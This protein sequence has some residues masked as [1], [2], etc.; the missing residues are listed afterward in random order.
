MSAWRKLILLGIVFSVAWGCGSTKGDADMEAE[1]LASTAKGS[2]VSD[3]NLRAQSLLANMSLEQK[4][5]QMIQGE[6]KHVTPDDVRRYGLG[7]VLNG[8]G[9]FPANNK[10]SSIGDW[11]DL[12]DAYRQ[13]SLDTSQGGAGIPILWGTDA[14]HGH[15]NVIG[16]TLFPHN[17]G[18]GAVNDPE[19]I[20]RIGRATAK[21]VAA[22]GID[23]IFAPTV[24]V[25]LDDRWGR[26]YE[27]Y[28]DRPEIVK[29]YSGVIVEALQEQGLLATAKHFIGD[30]GTYQGIDQGN[31]QVDLEELLAVHGQ[32]YVSALDAG[33]NSV[34]AS[35][36]SWNGDK[37]HGNK[38][39]LTDVLKGQLGFDGFV[40]SDWNGVGQV[41]GCTNASCAKAINAG[42]D[43][44][45]A[46]ED[47]R[48]LLDNTIAQVR[49]GE[50]PEARIDDAVSR[51]LRTKLAAQLFDAPLPSV[52]AAQHTDSVGSAEHRAIAREAVRKSLVL[53]KNDNGLLPLAPTQSVLVAGAGADSIEMQTGGWTISWQGTGNSNND[54]PGASSVFD[55]LNQAVTAEGGE[56]T[57]SVDGSFASKPD[58]AVVVFGE[59]PYAEGQGDVDTLAWQEE[60]NTD[61]ALLQNLKAQGIPVV[62]VL[63]TGRPMWMNAH[64]N[65]SDAFVVAWL[66]GS[67]GVGVADVLIAQANGNPRHDFTGRLSYDWP[68]KDLNVSDPALPVS[69]LLFEYGYGLSY[70]TPPMQLRRLNEEPVGKAKGLDRMVFSS[71]SKEP[72]REY[73]GDAGNWKILAE[74][75]VTKTTGGQLVMKAV[76]RFVQEDARQLIFSGTGAQASQVYWQSNAPVDLSDLLAADAALSV[77]LQMEEAPAGSVTLRIDCE[78]PCT[79]GLDVS[80]MLRDRAIGEWQRVSIPLDCFAAAGADFRRV[81]SPLVLIAD[82]TLSLRIS[83]ISLLVNAPAE[84][85]VSCPATISGE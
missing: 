82:N 63:L 16:A 73:V 29:A 61:L 37:I 69:D 50:I 24:A 38:A 19:L 80:G 45:M 67:E 1:A 71:G 30:G 57:L 72:W 52:R 85:L 27:G 9:S 66:P 59:T 3:L 78:Y 12:A 22:T 35:F 49:S 32:G 36:N 18:L 2:A 65:A 77:V 74:S 47:W 84:S 26:T 20:G 70:E 15:N 81:T 11:V 76:D 23:W 34:M 21:E 79:G 39:L 8:G 56:V 5:A 83:E 25:V 7:S 58:V 60:T 46:P 10:Y 40:I 68:N 41:D 13:A 54:F 55:G 64:I 17:I 42:M 48:E 14:V 53:L 51:I 6:I 31:T 62:A 75:A 44:I 43:M 28:S 4:V 33:V